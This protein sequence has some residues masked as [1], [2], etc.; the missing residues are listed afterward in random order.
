MCRLVCLYT[1]TLHCTDSQNYFHR[2][3]IYCRPEAHTRFP[4]NAAW[5]L[6]GE[7]QT[8]V[9]PWT[10][11][12]GAGGRSAPEP[13]M[14]C[15]L[16]RKGDSIKRL[17]NPFSRMTPCLTHLWAS[18]FA[19][20]GVNSHGH[21]K[22]QGPSSITHIKLRGFSPLSLPAPRSRGT[23]SSTC[24]Q[25]CP[26]TLK[27]GHWKSS[28][29]LRPKAH[30]LLP[31]RDRGWAKAKQLAFVHGYS[32]RGIPWEANQRNSIPK[33]S[34]GLRTWSSPPLSSSCTSCTSSLGKAGLRAFSWR[35]CCFLSCRSFK[36]IFKVK[37]TIET[38][39]YSHLKT[40]SSVK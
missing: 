26:L 39:Q 16:F 31:H 27:L 13:G 11:I 32:R 5:K 8:G 38:P 29:F 6:M 15:A 30:L 14:I 37:S 17:L 36:I 18:R 25:R 1:S 35:R 21:F 23:R 28:A 12:T 33:V 19:V 10:T 3:Q 20:N 2:P 34:S 40:S 4:W 7:V 22:L 24:S 9:R